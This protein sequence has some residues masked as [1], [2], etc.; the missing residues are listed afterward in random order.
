MNCILNKCAWAKDGC[1]RSLGECGA[2]H[3]LDRAREPGGYEV[4]SRDNR[5]I[6]GLVKAG[7]A[8]AVPADFG[9]ILIVKATASRRT[10]RAA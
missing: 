2:S 3:A 4:L 8:T 6:E 10:E 9:R 5:T 1:C 7:F